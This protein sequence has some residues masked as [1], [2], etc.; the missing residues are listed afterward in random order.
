MSAVRQQGITLGD[1]LGDEPSGNTAKQRGKRATEL[2]VT[3]VKADW[4]SYDITQ[5]VL[6]TRGHLLIDVGPD[7]LTR[8]YDRID[9][10]K[11]TR[12]L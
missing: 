4:V 5:G 12:T 8:G 11:S 7:Q 2:T 3:T 10:E 6:E 9:L 1:L